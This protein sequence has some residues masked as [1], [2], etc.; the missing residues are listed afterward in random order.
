MD[1]LIPT[2]KDACVQRREDS[3]MAAMARFAEDIE[4]EIEQICNANHQAFVSSVDQVSHVRKEAVH[5]TSEVLALTKSIHDSTQNLADKKKAL[6]D[7]RKTRQ[8][9][10]EA[11]QAL[12]LS[13][14]VLRLANSVHELLHQKKYYA[15]LRTLDELQNVHLKEVLQYN[16]ARII[17]KSVPSMKNM[18]KEAVMQDLNDWLFQIRESSKLIGQ[19]AFDQTELRRR[20]QK[21]RAEKSQYF[22]AFKLNSAVELVLDERE[23]FDV[24]ENEHV[25]IE[26]TPLYECLHIYGALGLRDEFRVEYS[27]V[28]AKQKELLITQ[29]V[30]FKN[31]DIQSLAKYLEDIAGFAIIERAT[32]KRTQNFRSGS[33]V[34]GVACIVICMKIFNDVYSFQSLPRFLILTL[35]Y[36]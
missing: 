19:V 21:E 5:V 8:N 3:L 29:T 6:V 34:C 33:D 7:L 10:E 11:R 32:I 28:R 25:V 12:Q 23:E 14:E 27:D 24:L 2:I 15:A 18:V 13:L 30:S 4:S 9:I 31:D 1:Q 20:R 22:E 17:Q 35:H 26:F 16:I 36:T